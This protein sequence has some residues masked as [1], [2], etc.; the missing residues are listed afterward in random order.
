MNPRA[1]SVLPCRAYA[2]M[3]DLDAERGFAKP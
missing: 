3:L 2:L 1:I